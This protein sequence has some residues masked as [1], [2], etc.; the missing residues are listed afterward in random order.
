MG[1]NILPNSLKQGVHTYH[2]HMHQ[3]TC[4][5]VVQL[6]T[7]FVY[8]GYHESQHISTANIQHFHLSHICTAESGLN[9]CSWSAD[10]SFEHQRLGL[11][12]PVVSS[13]YGTNSQV[14]LDFTSHYTGKRPQTVYREILEKT[15]RC[16]TPFFQ[17][18]GKRHHVKWN[19]RHHAHVPEYVEKQAKAKLAKGHECVVETVCANTT[20]DRSRSGDRRSL[21]QAKK[22]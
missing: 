22:E 16:S 3:Q 19:G 20:Q 6:Y 12:L 8:H 4:T 15:R 14:S 10:F 13:F 5:T 18:R 17:T 7:T 1:L 21:V 9:W 2:R 11:V